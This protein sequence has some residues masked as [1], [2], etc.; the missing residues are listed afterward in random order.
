MHAIH[1][2]MYDF[3]LLYNS[4]P[5][6]YRTLQCRDVSPFLE[7]VTIKKWENMSMHE[8]LI[9]DRG[10]G[11]IFITKHARTHAHRPGRTEI[12]LAPETHPHKVRQSFALYDEARPLRDGPGKRVR[13]RPSI[14]KHQEHSMEKNLTRRGMLKSAAGIAA[15]SLFNP[16]R[17]EASSADGIERRINVRVSPPGPKSLMLLEDVKKYV[18]RTNYSGLYG[19]GLKNGDGIYIEDI[20]GNVYIDCLTAASSTILG[21]SQDDIARTYYECAVK[22]QQTAFGYSPNAETV[23]LARRLA[24]ITPGDFP[25]KVLIGMSG[26]DSNCGAIEAAR[27]Y[28]GRMGIISFNFAYHGSTGLSQAASGFRSINEGAYDLSDPNFVKVPFP[29]T[30]EEAK[31]VLNSIESIIAFGRTAAVM[32][33]IIQGDGGTLLAPEGFFRQLHRLLKEHGVL[34]IDDEVQS[35]MGRTGRWCA[36]EHEGIEPE[37]VVLG[38]GLSAGYAPVSAIVGREEVIDSLVPAAHIFTYAGHGPSVSAASKTIDIIKEK[39]IIDNARKIGA[40]L[41][42]GLKEA[43]NYPDVVV[44]ARGRGCMIGIEINISKNPL[45]SKIFAY[46]CVEKGIYVGY[47]GDRQR[48]IRVLPPIILS[49]RECDTIIGIVLDTAAEMHDNRIPKATID[50]VKMFALGW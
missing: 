16:L 48:V 47:I 40:R 34:L 8:T 15:L 10:C 23:E 6:N 3:S 39:N 18:G 5:K 36:C 27:K 17:G 45:A 32:V 9:S 1:I 41:L 22:I 12:I 43:E 35:G 4:V 49:E 46:R 7:A 24:S 38:K 26:S 50:K 14:A 42:K 37:I 28:T 31:R 2:V 33:E 25:K 13:K 29:V 20:D 19:I 30:R 21:Y 11:L 44:E